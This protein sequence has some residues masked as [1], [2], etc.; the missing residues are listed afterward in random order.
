VSIPINETGITWPEDKGSKFKRNGDYKNKQ[1]IDPEDGISLLNKIFHYCNELEHFIVWMRTAGLPSFRK[2]W[3]K[4]NQTL[5]VG[6]YQMLI[7][8]RNF[9]NYNT[10]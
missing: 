1:W 4:I 8:N 10:F 2:L 6:N 7:D 9:N 3:G 5:E